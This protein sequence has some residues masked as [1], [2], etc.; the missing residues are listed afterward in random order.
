MTV[1]PAYIAN[2]VRVYTS[3]AIGCSQP[4]DALCLAIFAA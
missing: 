4:A 2:Y 3:S 1:V